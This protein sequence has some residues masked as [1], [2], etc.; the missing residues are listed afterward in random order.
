MKKR[1]ALLAAFLV[2]LSSAAYALDPPELVA[3]SEGSVVGNNP[4][5][6]WEDALAAEW[7]RVWVSLD[8]RGGNVLYCDYDSAVNLF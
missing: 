1:I 6:S 8:G 4:T 5:F 2:T 7:Y 3:P